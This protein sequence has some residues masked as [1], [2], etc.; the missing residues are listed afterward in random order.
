MLKKLEQFGIFFPTIEP[1]FT[2]PP[3]ERA[4]VEFVEAHESI[5]FPQY[6]A[7]AEAFVDNINHIKYEQFLTTQDLSVASVVYQNA[8]SKNLGTLF[9]LN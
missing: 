1:L 4:K 2:S 5:N 3:N 6:T 9:A 8:I 7:L